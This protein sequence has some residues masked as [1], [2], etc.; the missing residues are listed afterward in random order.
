MGEHVCLSVILTHTR[1]T[2]RAAPLWGVGLLCC[3][4]SAAIG[5]YIYR[6][7]VKCRLQRCNVGRT[8]VKQWPTTLSYTLVWHIKAFG[9]VVPP[10]VCFVRT[11]EPAVCGIK[12]CLRT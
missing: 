8:A 1:C 7:A 3:V 5:V 2:Q 11:V 4:G 12:L 6:R 9:L 10:P